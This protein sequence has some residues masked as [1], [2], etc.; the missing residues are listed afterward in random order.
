MAETTTTTT[1]QPKNIEL[2][3]AT[4][5]TYVNLVSSDG[6]RFFVPRTAAS[7]SVTMKAVFD[8][9]SGEDDNN[10]VPEFPSRQIPSDIFNLVARYM[11]W[12]FLDEEYNTHYQE[13]DF[14]ERYFHIPADKTIELLK[15]S[16]FLE[17]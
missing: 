13:L 11:V 3:K 12:K 7:F 15:A 4:K 9:P 10:S 6:F 2:P 14:P 16:H 5:A 17:L 8:L 1:T